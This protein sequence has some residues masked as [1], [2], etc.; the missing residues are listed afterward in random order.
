MRTKLLLATGAMLATL[1]LLELGLRVSDAIQGRGI[2]HTYSSVFEKPMVKTVPFR[3]FGFDPYRTVGGVRVISSR[4]G[5]IYPYHKAPGTFRIVC[6]GGSTTEDRID[7]LHYP[8]VLQTLLRKRLNR[9]DIEVIN[10]A[11]SSYATPH[12][13]ILLI[14][15]VISWQPD[16]VIISHNVNDL[17]AMYFPGFRPDYWN[18][19]SNPLFTTPDYSSRYSW[20]NVVFQH[21]RLYWFIKHRIESLQL[22]VAPPYPPIRRRS[23]GPDPLPEAAAVFARNLRTFVIV[24]DAW[25]IKTIIGSQPLEPSEEFFIRHMRFK[26][27][28]DV[29]VY[30]LHDEFVKHHHAFNRIAAEVAASTG[31]GFVDNDA[32]FGGDRKYFIDFVHYTKAGILKVAE[33]YA[34]FIL[35]HHMISADTLPQS[36]SKP[37]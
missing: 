19:F 17:L 29:V 13:L 20:S 37:R 22:R 14:L 15:D 8:L 10:V 35:A 23:Y 11:N 27:Y 31:A 3:T 9:S 25:H 7:G 18:K 21:S 24:A 1:L 33:D 4:W 28:N 12:A 30:P 34:D 26:P 2:F 5:E 32:V 6:F 16:L 36:R